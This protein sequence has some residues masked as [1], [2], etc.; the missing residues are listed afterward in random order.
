MPMSKM[1]HVITVVFALVAVLILPAKVVADVKVVGYIPSY[2]DIRQSID[3][4]QLDKLTHI[5]LAFVNPNAAGQVTA[6]GN[7]TC[8]KNGA[9]IN[10][11]GTDFKYVV[12]K[13]HAAGVKVMASVAGGVIPSCSGNWQT[14]LQ[15]GNRGAL[16]STLIAFVDEYNLDGLDI[17]IEGAVLTAID[18]SGNYTPF[19]QALSDELKPRGKLLTAATATYVGGMIP[20][21]SIPYFDFVTLMSYDAIGTSWGVPGAEHAT[22]A[23]AQSH[24]NTWISRGLSKDKLVLGVPFYGYGFGE[25]SGGLSFADILSRFGATAAN[26]DLIG[27]A[28]SGCSYIT[29]NGVPTIKAKSQ[30]AIDQGA[31][32]M[33]W[34]LSQDVNNGFSLLSTIWDVVGSSSGC[35]AWVEGQQYRVGDVVTYSDGNNYVA[36]H[37][38]PG[39]NP[40]ISTW[41]WDPSSESCGSTQFE[42][43]IEAE[44][45]SNMAGVQLEGTQDTGGGVNVG[46]IDRGDWM[47]YAGVVDLPTAGRYEI[48]YRVASPSGASLSADLDAGAI[49]LGVVSIPATGGWQTWTTVSHVVN[50]PA[51]TIN[52]GVF[53]QQSGWNINWINIKTIP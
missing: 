10:I 16:V 43:R 22:Y 41:F 20:I 51:G 45:Y 15:A 5:N 52:L 21:S 42:V 13:A 11:S 9:G 17:D 32:V 46:W 49:Q 34:E 25:Y 12:D 6:N 19:I 28:C 53:A 38:N 44:N 7:F 24:I 48:Q 27:T 50:L 4:T 8:M 39:Y 26:S 29:Y 2:K 18:N 14:L 23:A 47:A 30:L 31:G 36:V 3:Q 37:D 33:I 40:V 1:K 35:L